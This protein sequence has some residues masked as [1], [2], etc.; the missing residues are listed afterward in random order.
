M[1]T[2]MIA[3]RR[4]RAHA[5]DSLAT[6]VMVVMPLALW[7]SPRS[8][9]LLL[10]CAALLLVSASALSEEGAAAWAAVTAA[11]K[12]PP[13]VAGLS[14]LL[15]ACLS[16]LWS[17]QPLRSLRVMAELIVP[18]ASGLAVAVLWP[19]RASHRALVWIAFSLILGCLFIMVELRTG[20][21]M[22]MKMGLRPNT[23]IFNSVLTSFLLLTIPVLDGLLRNK[24]MFPRLLGAVLAAT[25]VA[26]LAFSESGAG[27]F[28][29]IVGL[30][31]FMLASLSS[32][33]ALCLLSTGFLVSLALAPV[34][35]DILD[36]AM[37]QA[38]HQRLQG[39][40]SRD[41]VDIW[42]SFGEAARTRP[43]LGAG[44]GTSATY[45][46]HPLV[47]EVTAERR[48]LLGAGH[49]HSLPV[50]IWAEMGLLGAMLAAFCG[51]S[52][53]VLLARIPDRHRP[54]PLALTA[55]VL[56][57]ATVGHGAWQAWWIAA[58]AASICWFRVHFSRHQPSPKRS[59]S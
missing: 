48:T 36:K 25:V 32:R 20:M 7:L 16:I 42:Q 43:L 41:R 37:P 4:F 22:R 45:Q 39:A 28:G 58:I 9:P 56:A 15:A 50:Q 12:S 53:T 6:I 34:M 19:S 14:F 23:F 49:A 59:G 55:A 8:G 35:G 3:E 33:F 21:V 17:H 1:R 57:V 29:L 51:L 52:L 27:L 10:V 5:L 24:A 38:I 31:F 40:H 26:T 2:G 46:E 47:H 13:G 11:L 44:F 30:F 54:A 18:L